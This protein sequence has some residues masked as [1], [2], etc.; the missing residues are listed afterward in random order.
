ML[1]SDELPAQSWIFLGYIKVFGRE[2]R[3]KAEAEATKIIKEVDVNG[4]GQIDFSGL[5]SFLLFIR[6]L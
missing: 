5:S 4:S 2:S 1:L 3:A 6:A